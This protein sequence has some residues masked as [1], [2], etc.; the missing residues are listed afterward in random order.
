MAKTD[1]L[2]EKEANVTE[3]NPGM[4][5]PKVGEIV[6]NYRGEYARVMSN[7][8]TRV[9]LS[10]WV[11]KREAAESAGSTAT[12]LNKFGLAQAT[13]KAQTV[14]SN[15]VSD[16]PLNT[17]EDTAVTSGVDTEAFKAASTI[18]AGATSAQ[19]KDYLAGVGESTNGDKAGRVTTAAEYVVAQGL[20]PNKVL[21]QL[22]A[23]SE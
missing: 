3:V 2:V 4:D 12:Y 6:E 7:S 16:A 18:L 13:G 9:G 11:R 21:E 10:P 20:E 23:D 8:Q 14:P 5:L 15:E 19:L 22:Q 17:D 1:N